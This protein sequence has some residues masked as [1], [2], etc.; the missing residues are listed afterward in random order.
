MNIIFVYG[1]MHTYY[2]IQQLLLKERGKGAV[3]LNPNCINEI[4]LLNQGVT[5][6]Q[7]YFFSPGDFTPSAFMYEESKT[8]IARLKT[9]NLSDLG[10][11]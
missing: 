2:K 3:E 11:N 10:V 5:E 1:H 6:N 8:P 4:G 7:K 9:L